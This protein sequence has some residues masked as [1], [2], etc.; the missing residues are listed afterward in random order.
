MAVVKRIWVRLNTNQFEKESHFIIIYICEKYSL[1]FRFSLKISIITQ[2][3][4]KVGEWLLFKFLTTPQPKNHLLNISR[5]SQAQI[6]SR[7]WR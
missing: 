7:R 1:F 4:A 6:Y 2:I 5:N 3:E